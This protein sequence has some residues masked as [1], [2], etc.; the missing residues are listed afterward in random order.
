MKYYYE[1]ILQYE[2]AIPFSEHHEKHKIIQ[3]ERVLERKKTA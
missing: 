3:T 1:W 2:M